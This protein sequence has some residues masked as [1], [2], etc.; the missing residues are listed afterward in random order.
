MEELIGL[1]KFEKEENV[2]AF[3]QDLLKQFKNMSDFIE[4]NP[5]L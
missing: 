1:S 5:N 2:E 4:D 3:R